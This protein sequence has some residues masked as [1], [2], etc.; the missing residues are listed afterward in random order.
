M[1]EDFNPPFADEAE[2]RDPTPQEEAGGFACGPADQALFNG[3]FHRLEGHLGEVISFAG[4]VPS[5]PLLGLRE[6]IEALIAAATGGGDTS[7]F[8]LI[9]QAR[10]RLPIFPDVDTVD[11]KINV[12]SPGVGVAR[13]VAGV[14]FSH[15]GIFP[16]TTAQTDLNTVA[17]KVY[18]LRW[19]P[20]D[21]FT[22]KDLSSGGYNPTLAPETDARFDTTYDD[23]LVA[24]VITNAGNVLTITPLS[25]KARLSRISAAEVNAGITNDGAPAWRYQY[26]F[27]VFQNWARRP[28]M[29][30]PQGWLASSIVAA[31]SSGLQGSSNVTVL[32]DYDRYGCTFNVSSDFD[33]AQSAPTAGYLLNI[34]AF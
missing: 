34:G 7:Q 29:I 20:T 17:S 13:V 26:T 16:V 24:R 12:V 27:A 1:A 14:T 5:A 4:I 33:V 9:T 23:M 10:A 25:N 19:N 2:I 3:L 31:G 21:G 22:L 6:A 32:N 28:N 11:G 30:I 18:H 15:R 8:L